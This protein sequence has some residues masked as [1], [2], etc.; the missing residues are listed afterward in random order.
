MWERHRSR[1][2]AKTGS[3]CTVCNQCLPCP[4]NIN[5]PGLLNLRNMTVAFDMDEYTRER[6]S[7]VG[8]GGAWVLGEKGDRCTKCGDCLPRC[9]EK[10]AILEL[11]WDGHQR[12]ETGKVSRPAWAHEGD[13]LKS[14]LKQV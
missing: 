10:L 12:M 1:C 8:S 11:L 9:P 4:E 2:T 13:L 14:D 3:F 7:M 6:Y 5:I